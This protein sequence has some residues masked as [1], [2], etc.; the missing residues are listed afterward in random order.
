MSATGRS[1]AT[2]TPTSRGI[3][4]LQPLRLHGHPDLLR[5]RRIRW[6]PC[7]EDD[8]AGV[9]RQAAHLH[10]RGCHHRQERAAVPHRLH[11]HGQGRRRRRQRRGSA[12]TARRRCWTGIASARSWPTRSRTSIRR[13]SGR[14]ATS[15]RSSRMFPKRCAAARRKRLYCAPARAWLQC[16]LRDGVDRRSPSVLHAVPASAGGVSGGTPAQGRAHLLIRRERSGRRW[17]ST[18][19]TF[20]T[21]ALSGDARDFLEDAIQDYN[22][23]FGTSYDTSRRPVPE[24]LQGSVAADEEPRDRSGHRRQHVPHR[25]RRDHTEHPVRRQEPALARPDPGVLADEPHPELGE[26]VR[27]HRLVPGP[28]GRDQRGAGAFRQQG[29]PGHGSPQAVSGVLRRLRGEGH[30]AAAAVPARTAD[31]RRS[32][33]EG[34]HRAVRRDP[35]ACRTS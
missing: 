18:T 26:D 8:R 1:S 21:D 19:R 12:S 9:R 22:D 20:D 17:P 29:G 13:P 3:Q 14:R 7:A 31:H 11:Q 27:Q 28:R 4:A 5:Q 2:C 34:F 10:D 33:A 16:A 24:L 25:L 30:H 6:Q 32:R 15:T 35:A 23:V